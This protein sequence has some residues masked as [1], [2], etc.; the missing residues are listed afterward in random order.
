MTRKNILVLGIAIGAAIGLYY[1]SRANYLFFHTTLEFATIVVG[2]LIFII[3][4]I[5]RKFNQK[6]FF[7]ALG[8]GVLVVSLLT[9]FHTITYR[10][11][12]IILGYDANLPTQLWVVL[13]YFLVFSFVYAI[14][15]G[16]RKTHY[17]LAIVGNVMLGVMAA[18]LCFFRLFPDCYVE[19]SGLTLFKKISEYILIFLYFGCILFVIAKKKQFTG[20]FFRGLLV[21]LGLF[22][23]SGFMFTLYQN[24]FGITNFLGHYLRLVAFVILYQF[25]VVEGI[26]KPYD[27]A[28][29]ELKELSVRDGLTK[30]YNHRSL[31]AFL[32]AFQEQ[33]VKNHVEVYLM[34]FDIDNFKTINDTYGHLTGDDVLKAVANVLT[35]TIRPSDIAVRQGGDEFSVI[36]PDSDDLTVTKTIEK[37]RQ[38]FKNT[39]VTDQNINVTVSGG[40]IKLGGEDVNTFLKRADQALYDAKQ[41]G[42]DQFIITF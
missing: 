10:G 28:F 14:W 8:P 2:L 40:V 29:A 38:T 31:L 11:T 26:S 23:V 20:P 6:S 35:Q 9:F 42:K 7:L 24:V 27:T 16:N 21:V 15:H 1:V 19:G 30:L 32:A 34:V 37:I 3:S 17:A 41:K 39:P 25:V 33:Q 4:W 36:F 5:S 12:G 22:I 13:S 18:L